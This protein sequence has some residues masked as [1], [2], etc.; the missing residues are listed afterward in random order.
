M[1]A[2]VPLHPDA[3]SERDDLDLR[4]RFQSLDALL[5][6]HENFWK[7]RP[8]EEV[9]PN[10]RHTHP[11]LYNAVISLSD[12][13]VE[14]CSAE[15]AR[16]Q[17]IAHPFLPWLQELA[18][19]SELVA[20]PSRSLTFSPFDALHAPGRKWRQVTAF[21]AALPPLSGPVHDWCSGK[22]HLARAV[23]DA[24][25]VELF[26]FELDA[27]LCESGQ[28]LADKQKLPIR[29]IR[30]DLLQPFDSRR[31]EY[32]GGWRLGLHAC[33]QLHVN[34]LRASVDSAADGVAIA[35]CCYHKLCLGE[36]YQPLS[37]TAREAKLTLS[38]KDVSLAVQE[39]VTA[40]AKERAQ[41]EK[42]SQ[43]RLGFDQLQRQLRSQDEYLPTPSLPK[44]MLNGDFNAFCAWAAREK[45]LTLPTDIDYS[46]FAETGRSRYREVRRL[47]LVR[48]LFRRPLEIWL[49]LDRAL[50]LQERGY[51]VTVREFCSREITPR[52]IL[53]TGQL[54]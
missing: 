31:E 45:H 52:N 38:L 43:W 22:G 16:F 29:Y 32:R 26:C 14:S 7:P 41:R 3:V 19:A 9:L 1:S 24:N 13:V 37:K 27:Q 20:A 34:L 4:Q 17:A 23:A 44:A 28:T 50:F 53:I 36:Q 5:A 48:H 42:E 40:S 46:H 8:F 47:E 35:P 18:R 15:P 51:E 30:Q 54:L 25:N 21:A 6:V 39:T 49:A 2:A 11:E 12:T 10:W 33:G